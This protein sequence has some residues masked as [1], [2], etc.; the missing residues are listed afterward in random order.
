MNRDLEEECKNRTSQFEEGQKDTKEKIDS[1]LSSNHR[2]QLI[3]REGETGSHSKRKIEYGETEW[4]VIFAERE[5]EAG[6]RWTK[7]EDK[8]VGEEYQPLISFSTKI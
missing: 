3:Y 7:L 8:G 6:E 1:T 4:I 2:D 5:L